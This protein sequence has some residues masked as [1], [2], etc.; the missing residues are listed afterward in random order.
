[1]SQAKVDKYKKEKKN[2]AKNIKKAKAKKVAGIFVGAAIVGTV[3]GVPLGRHMYNVSVEER[4]ANATIKVEL[5]DYW[6]QQYWAEKYSDLIIDEEPYA[7]D[8]DAAT[9]SD[10]DLDELFDATESDALSSDAE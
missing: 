2:R 3:I 1:M 6:I 8:T 4:K 10:A 9:Y 5:Y 7:S